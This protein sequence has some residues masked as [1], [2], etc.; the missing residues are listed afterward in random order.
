MTRLEDIDIIAVHKADDVV[1]TLPVG[2]AR[3]EIRK[4]FPGRLEPGKLRDVMDHDAKRIARMLR[5][6]LPA[7]TLSRVTAYL[8]SGAASDMR[9]RAK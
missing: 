5:N 2:E 8:L 7:G 1:E 4:S 6:Y 9:V 3:I